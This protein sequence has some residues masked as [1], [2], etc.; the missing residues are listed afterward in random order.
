MCGINVFFSL[1]VVLY[2]S[3]VFYGYRIHLMLLIQAPIIL[4]V[5][6]IPKLIEDN[7][8]AYKVTLCLLFCTAFLTA[9]SQSSVCGHASII[10]EKYVANVFFGYGFGSI[11]I[12]VVR[13]ISLLIFSD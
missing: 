9:V 7:E 1:G 12:N 6:F 13:I 4:I 11:L 5:P 8:A 10:S 3:K 2:G